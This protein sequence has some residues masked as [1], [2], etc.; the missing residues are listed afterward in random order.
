M[1]TGQWLGPLNGFGLARFEY[2]SAG[3]GI[4]REQSGAAG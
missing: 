1:V 3:G 2:E 4:L